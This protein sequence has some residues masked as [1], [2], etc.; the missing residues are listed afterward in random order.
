MAYVK[1]LIASDH[2]QIAYTTHLTERQYHLSL[3]LSFR[4]VRDAKL[5][6][7]LGRRQRQIPWKGLRA[8]YLPIYNLFSLGR[9]IFPFKQKTALNLFKNNFVVFH[10]LILLSIWFLWLNS[11]SIYYLS[12]R[13]HLK[14]AV[15]NQYPHFKVTHIIVYIKKISWWEFNRQIETKQL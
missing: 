3:D 13:A 8:D 15:I 2:S 5:L 14:S 12:Y 6:C 10:W 11:V 4:Y 1:I 9:L 7:P